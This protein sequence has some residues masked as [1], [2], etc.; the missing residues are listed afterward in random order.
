[1]KTALDNLDIKPDLVLTD[2]VAIETNLPQINIIKG[3]QKSQVIAAASIISKVTRD[4]LMFKYSVEYPMYGFDKNK[5]YPTKSHVESI[6]K[7]GIT[8]IHRKSFKPIKEINDLK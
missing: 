1:M 4:L 8:K 3:D 7:Y 2:Y 6:K 5:G